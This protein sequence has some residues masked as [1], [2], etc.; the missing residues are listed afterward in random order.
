MSG[1][2]SIVDTF[3][4]LKSDEPV[5]K[6]IFRMCACDGNH[7]YILLSNSEGKGMISPKI[8]SK[9]QSLKLVKEAEEHHG[10]VKEEAD[11]LI[12]E[13]DESALPKFSDGEEDK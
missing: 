2:S 11:R 12:K 10:L 7:A 6:P 13:I 3:P 1:G 4:E 8:Q 9:H 5:T